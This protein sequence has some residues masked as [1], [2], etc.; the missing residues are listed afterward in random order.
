[1]VNG[2]SPMDDNIQQIMQK[3]IPKLAVESDQ[4][5]E[6][7]G[8]QNTTNTTEKYPPKASGQH[9]MEYTQMT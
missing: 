7:N 9:S 2:R 1:M 5:R 3:N 4:W 6:S 8:W